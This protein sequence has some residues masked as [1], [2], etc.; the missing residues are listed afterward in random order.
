MVKAAGKF[1]YGNS[2]QVSTCEP[3]K[4]PNAYRRGYGG[5]GWDY[6][7]RRIFIRDKYKCQDCGRTCTPGSADNR[8][9]PH[10]DH[11]VPL[12]QGGTDTDDNKQTLCGK[13][14][15][16]KTRTERGGGVK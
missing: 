13:C 14:H 7:R 2:G 4:R 1:G 11:I 10:C 12:S 9:R 3:G 16:K 5:K 8:D 6:S 15:G